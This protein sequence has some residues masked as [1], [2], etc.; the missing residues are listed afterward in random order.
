MLAIGND[1]L[2][3]L[4]PLGETI[5][6]WRCGEDHAVEH[7]T[8]RDA[9]GNPAPSILAFMECGGKSWLCGIKGREWRPTP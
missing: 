1:E 3:A 5:R 4:P 9:D 2:S 6:C 8:S 7:A